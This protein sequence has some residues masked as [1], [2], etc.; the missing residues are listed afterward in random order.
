[1]F[2]FFIT[3]NRKN[4]NVDSICQIKQV[5]FKHIGN[6]IALFE[7]EVATLKII[8]DMARM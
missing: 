8:Y 3:T 6:V 1:M 4:T 7:V 2:N 5:F